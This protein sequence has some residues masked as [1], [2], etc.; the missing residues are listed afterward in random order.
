M[1]NKN[2]GKGKG[3]TALLDP[4]KLKS[5]RVYGAT[6]GSPC[7]LRK[8]AKTNPSQTPSSPLAS[9]TTRA[10][11]DP[12]TNSDPKVVARLEIVVSLRGKY[13]LLPF[14]FT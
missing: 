4:K 9:M 6:K 12:I 13:L 1:L 11:Q 14:H 7:P 5:L 2:E 8:T 10:R 3:V